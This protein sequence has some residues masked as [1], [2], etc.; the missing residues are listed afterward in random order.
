VI[1]RLDDQ[2]LKPSQIYKV[3]KGAS[4]EELV[5]F[6]VKTQGSAPEACIKNFLMEYRMVRLLLR[7][8]DLMK[9]GIK[10]GKKM[11]EI[12][13]YLLE[14][15]MDSGIKTREEETRMLEQMDFS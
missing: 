10:D 15:K 13:Q 4:L 9:I 1:K 3:L 12:L 2:T 5:F 7:G 8:D 14:R 6:L 11:G